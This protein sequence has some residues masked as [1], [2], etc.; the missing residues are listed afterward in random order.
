MRGVEL[1]EVREDEQVARR[2]PE[3]A[4]VSLL[5]A[6]GKQYDSPG[7]RQLPGGAAPGGPG[8]LLRRRRPVRARSGVGRPPPVAR[9]DDAPAPARP[10]RPA[11]ADLPRPQ[12]PRE[13]ALP[14]LRRGGGSRRTAGTLRAVTPLQDL[15]AAVEAASA[16]LRDGA[17]KGG[18]AP[19]VERPRRDGFGDYSTNAAMLLAPS[20][21]APPRE[22]AERLGRRSQQRLGGGLDRYEVAG[23]GLPQPLPGRRLARPTR[24]RTC[25]SGRRLRRAAA[26]PSPS[27][28]SSSSSA[29]TRP[30]RSSPPAA[31]TPPTATRSREIL[32][33]HGHEVQREYYVND[34]GAQVRKLG[35]S[36]QARALGEDVPEGGYEGDYVA[37]LAQEIP[38]SATADP[39]DLA[40][41][42]VAKMLAAHPGD[43]RAL[44]RQTRPLV[45]RA[46]AV[47]GRSERR[48]TRVRGAGGERAHL[49][50]RGRA[51]AAHDDVRRRQGPRAGARERRADLLR[52][53][54]RLPCSTSRR[55]GS[56]GRSTSS[57]PTTTATSRG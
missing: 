10:R 1:V 14:L 33:F 25:S 26:R 57:A 4:F 30:G 39:D 6:E 27:G 23:P 48:Q 17:A 19:T 37:E 38:D 52:L 45:Q 5:D 32:A 11:G 43:A 44:R 54:L 49:P 2:I 34:A 51:V 41:E 21:G 16:A 35:E 50:L 24:S 15:R 9:R 13:R 42:A 12:D 22:I 18:T 20:V 40:Q 7:V 55:A 8:R 29:P 3:R 47:R 46:L 36:V 28:S 56:S 31:A 53:R